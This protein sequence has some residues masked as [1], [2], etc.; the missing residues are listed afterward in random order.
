MAHTINS[1]CTSCGQ[2]VDA[3]YVNAIVAGNPYKITDDC[4]DCGVCADVCPAGAIEG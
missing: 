3:C 2:C 4:V 1:S